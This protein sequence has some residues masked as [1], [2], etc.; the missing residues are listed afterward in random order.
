MAPCVFL[1]KKESWMDL[2]VQG[3]ALF[4]VVY[5]TDNPNRDLCAVSVFLAWTEG[6]I[7]LSQH[8]K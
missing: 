6:L 2:L 8:P 1:M 7:L 4:Y 3:F 5:G